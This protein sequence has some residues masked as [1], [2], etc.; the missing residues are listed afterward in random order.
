[1]KLKYLWIM[2][3]CAFEYVT[4]QLKSCMGAHCMWQ[5]IPKSQECCAER[6]QT[7]PYLL[8]WQQRVAALREGISILP[9][10]WPIRWHVPSHILP[11]GSWTS[12]V[13]RKCVTFWALF[14]VKFWQVLKHYRLCTLGFMVKQRECEPITKVDSRPREKW[15]QCHLRKWKSFFDRNSGKEKKRLYQQ[16]Q[17]LA[18]CIS[19]R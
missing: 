19:E 13:T 11:L 16:K 3:A 4:E 9:V 1:M 7:A 5:N 12:M 6:F 18:L 17:Q 15:W 14:C 10:L 8:S 2:K